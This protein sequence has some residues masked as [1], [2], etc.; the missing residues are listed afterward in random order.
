AAVFAGA[1]VVATMIA[2]HPGLSVAAHNGSHLV[3]SGPGESVALAE[4]AFAAKG[5]RTKRLRTSHA[6]HSA[7]LDPILDEFES[8]AG[9][10]TFHAAHCPLVCNVSGET[11]AADRI[12]DGAYW[13]HHL[14]EA[15]QYDKSIRGLESL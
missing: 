15:V 4:E 5:I 1:E 6:F 14:R 11:L 2:A 13:R 10:L 8:I 12:L 9:T 7:L 3:I